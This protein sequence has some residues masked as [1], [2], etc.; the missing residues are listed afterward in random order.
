MYRQQ[1]ALCDNKLLTLA[2]LLLYCSKLLM[3]DPDITAILSSYS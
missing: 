2:C 3:N 1:L